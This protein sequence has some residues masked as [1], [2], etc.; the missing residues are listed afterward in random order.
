M[1]MA[2]PTARASQGHS[3]HFCAANT[4]LA[5]LLLP[6]HCG[7]MLKNKGLR[8]SKRLPKNAL[9]EDCL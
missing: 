4:S 5:A 7:N 8:P 6:L 9:G 1:F 2:L 3:P